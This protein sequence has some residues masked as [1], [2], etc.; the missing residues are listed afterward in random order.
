[1][2]KRSEHEHKTQESAVAR[3]AAH[4]ITH[5]SALNGLG[6]WVMRQPGTSDLWVEVVELHGGV[7][8][9]HGDIGPQLWARG[10]SRAPGDLVQWMGS[11]GS[12]SDCYLREKSS[13]AMGCDTA[14]EF[15][16][17]IAVEDAQ[18]FVQKT[19]TDHE[20]RPHQYRNSGW[21][22]RFA[23]AC[24]IIRNDDVSHERAC[25]LWSK[26]FTA[27]DEWESYPNWGMVTEFH[28]A[29]AWAALVRLRGLLGSET[30]EAREV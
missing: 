6:R 22:N 14:R 26:V 27:H 16:S 30:A 25:R 5:Q 19:L 29:L 11:R 24:Q 3:F 13:I 20:G 2:S 18:A 1:M 9:V 8:L 21:R 28:F 17:G 7:L 23:T 15:D 4:T 12:P 10:T